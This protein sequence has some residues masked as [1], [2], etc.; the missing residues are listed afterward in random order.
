[1]KLPLKKARTIAGLTC[2]ELA[3]RIG[4]SLSLIH[5]V[6]R[7]ERGVGISHRFAVRASTVLNLTPDEIAEFEI[8]VSDILRK[9]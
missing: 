8:D 7:G 5:M 4:C 6:E 1:M 3:D 9:R 2:Q